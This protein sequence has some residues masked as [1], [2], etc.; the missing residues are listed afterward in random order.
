MP[1]SNASSSMLTPKPGFT[2]TGHSENHTMSGQSACFEQHPFVGYAFTA[3]VELA[4]FNIHLR[5]VPPS[6]A[7]NKA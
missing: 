6:D 5:K 1:L 2:R 3:D 7:I 4:L